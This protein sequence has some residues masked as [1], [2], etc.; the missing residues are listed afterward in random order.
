MPLVELV[1]HH[2]TD[3]L[4]SRIGEQA[5]GKNAFRQKSQPRSRTGYFFEANLVSDGLAHGLS[6]LPCYEASSQPRREPAGFQY[7]HITP[8]QIEERGRNARGLTR[9]GWRFQNQ[10][11]C[12]PEVPDDFGDQRIEA[13]Y[14]NITAG[15]DSS[16]IIKM[17]AIS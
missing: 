11:R 12:V 8:N 17:C 2:A 4:Q 13:H 3:S 7:Q 10:A 9:P 1:E 5:P 14:P 15:M 16:F 6:A